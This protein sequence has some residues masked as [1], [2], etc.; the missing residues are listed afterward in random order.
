MPNLEYYSRMRIPFLL[1]GV[2]FIDLYF[3][4]YL[5]Q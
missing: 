3:L 5:Q 1:E 2:R 4:A